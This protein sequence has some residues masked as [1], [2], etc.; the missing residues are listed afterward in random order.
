MG[1]Q[2]DGRDS[3][4]FW[5]RGRAVY[6]GCRYARALPFWLIR[7]TIYE[8]CWRLA[9]DGSI[10]TSID[11]EFRDTVIRMYSDLLPQVRRAYISRGAIVV[12]QEIIKRLCKMEEGNPEAEIIDICCEIFPEVLESRKSSS[13]GFACV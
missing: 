12:V 4:A 9:S 11:F 13:S 7:R 2:L 6:R 8:H 3:V 10:S 1:G 5:G